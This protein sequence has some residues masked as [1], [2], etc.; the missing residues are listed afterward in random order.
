MPPFQEN[1]AAL[2]TRVTSAGLWEGCHS[3]RPPGNCLRGLSSQQAPC[4]SSR[5]G[6]WPVAG[7]GRA[8]AGAGTWPCVP[9]LCGPTCHGIC[10][11]LVTMALPP[12]GCGGSRAGLSNP[13]RAAEDR[14]QFK[15][16][17]YHL[18]GFK[19]K[20]RQRFPEEQIKEPVGKVGKGS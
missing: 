10:P 13:T 8:R 7:A 20:G 16:S 3:Q 19:C 17:C 6:V 18:P 2:W 12:L 14:V 15:T 11:A 1:N 5:P 4:T 9:A